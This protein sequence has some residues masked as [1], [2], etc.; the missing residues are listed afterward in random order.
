M[1]AITQAGD[2]QRRPRHSRGVSITG[3]ASQDGETRPGANASARRLA[4]R[5][6]VRRLGRR[7][8]ERQWRAEY[9]YD[10]TLATRR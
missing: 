6:S 7:A 5:A 1:A 4:R 8:G 2:Y 10:L 3:P 9:R